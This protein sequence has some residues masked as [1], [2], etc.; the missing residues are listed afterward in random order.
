MVNSVKCCREIE[1]NKHDGVVSVN[2]I[3]MILE[4]FFCFCVF[5]AIIVVTVGALVSKVIIIRN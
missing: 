1:S 2:S 5:R 3:Y 4:N